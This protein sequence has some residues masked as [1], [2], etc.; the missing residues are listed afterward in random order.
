MTNV[1]QALINRYLEHKTRPD[2]QQFITISSH[3]Q[4]IPSTGTFIFPKP[5]QPDSNS[6]TQYFISGISFPN[7]DD[8]LALQKTEL[9]IQIICG[10]QTWVAGQLG[11]LD[12]HALK[13]LIIP[14]P[15]ADVQQEIEIIILNSTTEN[16]HGSGS[17]NYDVVVAP[18][19]HAED[20]HCYRQIIYPLPESG[21]IHD[22]RN[23][24]LG[25]IPN[26]I[27]RVEVYVPAELDVEL[28]LDYQPKIYC[29][30]LAIKPST[31]TETTSARTSSLVWDD[32]TTSARTPSLVWDG[33][34]TSARTSSLVWDDE[35]TSA[36]THKQ[37]SGPGHRK[38]LGYKTYCFD[39]TKIA[40]NSL[41]RLEPQHHGQTQIL[42]SLIENQV[43]RMK[44][45]YIGLAF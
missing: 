25:S 31:Q 19:F 35:T 44:S 38:C 4:T 8:N 23:T 16:S 10:G 7:L 17:L 29:D 40:P 18:D 36:R 20:L 30:Y 12:T 2:P 13:D 28:P 21:I 3:H 11:L 6:K 15:A 22:G 34:T 26:S 27:A 43:V 32:E 33:E 24:I 41:I 37:L 9:H 39:G 14:I 5:P 45:G 42:Y 1:Y